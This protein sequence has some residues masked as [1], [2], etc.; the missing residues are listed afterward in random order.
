MLNCFVLTIIASSSSCC[1]ATSPAFV[2]PKQ[3]S[4]CPLCVLGSGQGGG[5]HRPG[6]GPTQ[7]Q[8]SG[9]EGGAG[10]V[11]VVDQAHAAGDRDRRGEGLAH[12][13]TPLCPGQP[14]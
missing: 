1:V 2:V 6:A 5:N 8:R 12:V 11:H 9:G 4:R 3:T 7:R 13:R 10:R 14:A